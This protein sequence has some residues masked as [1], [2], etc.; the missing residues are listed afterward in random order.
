MNLENNFL[1]FLKNNDDYK[2]IIYSGTLDKLKEAYIICKYSFKNQNFN[3]ENFVKD[4]KSIKI[5]DIIKLNFTFDEIMSFKKKKIDFY[6]ISKER[7]QKILNKKNIDMDFTTYIYFSDKKENK[8]LYFENEWK[9]ICFKVKKI[10]IPNA[11]NQPN[12]LPMNNGINPGYNQFIND[13]N[14]NINLKNNHLNES[15]I[16]N[17]GQNNDDIKY[18]HLI[19]ENNKLRDELGKYKNL[20]EQLQ[21]KIEELSNENI[22]LNNQL[23]NAAKTISNFSSNNLQQNNNVINNFIEMLKTKD[24]EISDLK[25]KMQKSGKDKKLIDFNDIIVINFISSD[26]KIN[27]GIQ[28]LKTETFAEVEERLYQKYEEFR[29][30]NN[31]FIAKGGI[32]LRFKK[33]CENN[34]QDGDKVQLLTI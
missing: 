26:S 16:N 34:L 14:D 5:P 7:L 10:L 21:A 8:L 13:Y 32:I 15:N 27:T 12:I 23:I 18:S 25:L 28:C 4:E 3:I 31:N 11:N 6:I 30:T 24:K 17:F 22:N 1:F 2:E 9:F 19:A 20:N 29:E 33:I